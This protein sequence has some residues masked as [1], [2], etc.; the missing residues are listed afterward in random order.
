MAKFTPFKSDAAALPSADLAYWM[1]PAATLGGKPGALFPTP[2]F[3]HKPTSTDDWVATSEDTVKVLGLD[4]FGNYADADGNPLAAVRIT[5]VASS[6]GLQ[7]D[8]SGRGEWVKVLQNQI[9]GANDI[10]DGRLRFVPDPDENGDAYATIGF[11]VSDG[12]DFSTAA[13]TL[14]VDVAPVNDAPI[15]RNDS[16]TVNESGVII[17]AN[18]LANDSDVDS[19]LTPANITSFSQGAH[20]TVFSN[21]NGTFV[22]RHDGSETTNDSFTYTIAD[23]LGATSTATVQVTINPVNDSPVA[24]ADN[25]TVNEGG[26]ATTVNVLANDSDVDSPLTPASITGFTQGA[27]RTAVNNGN[28]TFTYPHDG[29]ETTSDSFTYTIT[30][31]HGATSTATVQVLAIPVND[32]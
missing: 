21:G 25:A 14:T 23:S 8:V 30:D 20:G 5:T 16:A 17:T 27:H 32:A 19:S 31:D 26:T 22:Y 28:G 15:A 29:S 12:M 9:I 6:G 4:D 13:Y 3:N 11:R 2:R 1:D 18:V 7:Y 24:R 10:A